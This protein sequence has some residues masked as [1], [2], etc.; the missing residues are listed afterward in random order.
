[1]PIRSLQRTKSSG[2]QM[3]INNRTPTKIHDTRGPE[4]KSAAI[5]RQFQGQQRH[6]SYSVLAG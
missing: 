2:W 4:R 6:R 1:M 5:C 3:E